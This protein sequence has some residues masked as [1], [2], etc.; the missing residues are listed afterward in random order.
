MAIVGRNESLMTAK[1]VDDVTDSH[2][3]KT[4]EGWGLGAAVTVTGFL[5]GMEGCAVIGQTMINVKVSQ[6]Q[7]RISTFA[8]SIRL[9]G[10]RSA[11]VST[12]T[13]EPDVL[14]PLRPFRRLPE[15]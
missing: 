2:S 8:A 5:G 6:A 4:R 13:T 1:L 3:D 15:R 11:G 9:V 10:M 7:T 14:T 12:D